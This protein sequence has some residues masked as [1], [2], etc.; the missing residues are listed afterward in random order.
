MNGLNLLEAY[1]V[2]QTMKGV[3]PEN[4][5]SQFIQESF[6][7]L[8]GTGQDISMVRNLVINLSNKDPQTALKKLI[9][10]HGLWLEF[11]EK[12]KK[13]EDSNVSDN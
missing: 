10:F 3:N 11:V 5:I 13:I 8:F 12:S 7:A 6:D 1:K 9:E 2:M 4:N